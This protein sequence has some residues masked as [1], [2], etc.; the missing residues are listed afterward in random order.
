LESSPEAYV[1]EL[2]DV[3]RE[4]RRVLRP[5]GVVWLNLGDSYA[6]YW[7]DSTARAKNVRS[8]ADTNGWTNGFN[9]NAKPSFHEAF[10]YG[11][12][13]PKDLVGIPWMVAFALRND[14]WYLRQDI[15]WAKP[16]PMP[17]SVGDR[18]TKAHEY[19]F[20]LAHPDGGGKYYYDWEAISDSLT[21][22]PHAPGNKASKDAGHLRNDIGTEA[23][24][25][26]WGSNGRKNKR[27]VWNVTTKPYSGA[28]FA[29]WPP[30]LVEPMILAGSSTG[31]CCPHCGKPWKNLPRGSE[32]PNHQGRTQLSAQGERL[33]TGRAGMNRPR[34][35][36]E[37]QYTTLPQLEIAK[38]LRDAASGRESE[39]QSEFG[40]KWGHWTRTDSSGARIPTFE[41]AERIQEILGVVI[42]FE[43]SDSR[44]LGDWAQSCGCPTHQPLPCT[45]LDPFSGSATTGMVALQLGRNYIGIDLNEEYLPLAEARLNNQSAPQP[46]PPHEEEDDIFSLFGGES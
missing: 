36:H 43:L 9:M 17:E 11:S 12:I 39:M 42:P 21:T 14:G 10:S 40:S 4:I 38:M 15:I 13:K 8:S 22:P 2:V 46:L 28:H 7:G 33:S 18:C 23:M 41:D 29:T 25:R 24:D 20:L 19:I 3:F 32:P 1:Q 6:G 45:I 27:S 5:D 44:Q 37:S 26:V 30:D 34:H 31:G 35:G 16:N